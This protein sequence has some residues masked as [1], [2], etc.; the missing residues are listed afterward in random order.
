V[1]ADAIAL[2]AHSNPCRIKAL[3]KAALDA[4]EYCPYALSVIER[5]A[6]SA[7]LRNE[8]LEQKPIILSDLMR[9]SIQDSTKFK[10]VEFFFKYFGL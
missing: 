4:L 5:L 3:V 2:W 9:V 7:R 8:I 6:G 1:D 10:K